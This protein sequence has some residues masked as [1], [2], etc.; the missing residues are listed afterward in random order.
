MF[1]RTTTGIA[2]VA[3]LLCSGLAGAQ[4]IIPLPPGDP[5]A[6]Q[7][8]GQRAAPTQQAKPAQ[9]QRPSWRLGGTWQR[10][11]QQLAVVNGQTVEVGSQ[12]QGARVAAIE[13]G[14]VTL[15]YLGRAVVLRD[16]SSAADAPILTPHGAN[17]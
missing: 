10:G 15:S 9:P 11:A 14:K 17:L 6:A 4:D 1:R 13:P 5:M 2:G 3:W 8:R 7:T 16:N 12:V